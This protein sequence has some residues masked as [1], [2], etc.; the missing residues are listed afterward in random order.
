[1]RLDLSHAP[2]DVL[3]DD[4][5]SVGDI[6]R[7]AGGQPGFWWIISVTPNGDAY[8][9]AFDNSGQITGAQRYGRSYFAERDHRRVGRADV[10]PIN[11]EWI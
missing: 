4:N 6:Y 2:A 10:P 1:M 8:A 7:K 11:V 9:L 5:P 3:K